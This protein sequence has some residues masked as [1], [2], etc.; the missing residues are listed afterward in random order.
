MDIAKLSMNISRAQTLQDVGMAVLNNALDM[1]KVQA[2]GM[3][4]II[5]SASLESITNPS[6]GQHIDLSI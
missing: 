5:D 3:T 6:V 1:Q 2:D 4:E